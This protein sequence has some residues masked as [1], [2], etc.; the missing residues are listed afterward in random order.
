MPVRG[1]A[2]PRLEGQPIKVALLPWLTVSGGKLLS[3]ESRGHEVHAASFL[4]TRR[5]V[6]D[7]ALV[8]DPP[9]FERILVHEIFHFVWLRMGNVKRQSFESLLAG[10]RSRGELGFSAEALKGKLTESD[11]ARRSK[12]WRAYACESFCDT[13]AWYYS[14]LARH[15]EWTLAARF[16]QQRAAWFRESFDGATAS[17]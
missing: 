5:I 11:R 14:T 7:R 6:L 9:N 1:R 8:D 3:R 2:L 10:E 17:I 4:R 12:R 16:R 15:E 13:A